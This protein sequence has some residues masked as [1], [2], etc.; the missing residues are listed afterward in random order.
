MA[1]LYKGMFNHRKLLARQMRLHNQRPRRPNK[2]AWQRESIEMSIRERLWR[3]RALQDRCKMNI[4]QRTTCLRLMLRM[5]KKEL[6][7]KVVTRIM[8]QP[9][10]GRATKLSQVYLHH[11]GDLLCTTLWLLTR[12]HKKNQSR[13]TMI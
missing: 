7:V 13:S 1:I 3:S 6:E 2:M 10:F 8:A 4:T 5:R 11:S 9:T 12:K